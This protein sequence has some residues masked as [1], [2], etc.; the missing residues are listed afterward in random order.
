M[1]GH[2]GEMV[3]LFRFWYPKRGGRLSC[4]KF[5]KM[6]VKITRMATRTVVQ[7]IGIP[8]LSD[9]VKVNSPVS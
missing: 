5:Q 1:T 6:T 7:Y 3:K 2:E 4:E 8:S 9:Y